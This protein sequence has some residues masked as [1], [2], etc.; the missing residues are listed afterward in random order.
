MKKLPNIFKPGMNHDINNN[1][2][3]YYSFVEQVQN[4][5][6]NNVNIKEEVII[7]T[8]SGEYKTSIR[9]RIGNHFL[10]ENGKAVPISD[11]VSIKKA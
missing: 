1:R 11:I 5:L 10:L 8:K 7:I 2:E 9:S 4:N 3:V 6:R